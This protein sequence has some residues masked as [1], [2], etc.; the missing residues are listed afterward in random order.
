[1]PDFRH[2]L[3][4][5]RK[6]TT[7]F[8]NQPE[9]FRPVFQINSAK[10][11][12]TILK[13][14]VNDASPDY[15]YCFKKQSMHQISWEIAILQF[16]WKKQVMSGGSVPVLKPLLDHPSPSY[17]H[18]IDLNLGDWD[19]FASRNLSTNMATKSLMLIKGMQE[20][21]YLWCLGRYQPWVKC[22]KSH[23]ALS[24]CSL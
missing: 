6:K 9:I 20:L 22:E 3:H 13:M 8:I 14:E 23:V 24:R 1:M 4:F 5:Q 10:T 17:R 21:R 2:Q 12:W 16:S 7:P 18:K 11:K 19:W 15:V